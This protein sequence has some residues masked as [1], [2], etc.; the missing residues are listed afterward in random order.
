MTSIFPFT[1]L[2]AIGARHTAPRLWPA[3]VG[4][5]LVLLTACALAPLHGSAPSQP[6]AEGAVALRGQ[7]TVDAST[8]AASP[9][10]L[11][12]PA[13]SV[14]PTSVAPSPTPLPTATPDPRGTLLERRHLATVQRDQINQTSARLYPSGT[15]LP[16]RYPVDRFHIR[17]LSTDATGAPLEVVAQLFVPRVEAALSAPVFV[18]GAGTTGLGDQCAPSREQPTVRNWGDYL[19]HMQSYATQGY[20]AI[21]PDY[22]GFNDESQLQRYFIADLEG[23]VLLD[24]ARAVY[25]F[26]EDAA[27]PV[28]PERAVFFAGYSQGGHAAFAARDAAPRYAPDVPIAGAIGH[29]ATTDVKALLRDSPY[30]APYVLYAYAD[31]YGTDAVDVSRLLLPRWLPSLAVEM[32]TKCIDAMPGYYGNEPRQLY[33]AGFLNALF[34]DRLGESFPALDEVL[35]RNSTGLVPS[36]VPALLLQGTAD[37]IVPPRTQEAFVAKLCAAGGRVTYLTYPNVHHFQ[38]RQVSFK[39]TLAWM[40]TIRTGGTPRT[41]CTG[42]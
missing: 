30:F 38:T 6:A 14:S 12:R 18:Y 39:D 13:A 37:P 42:S 11:V 23:R 10:P 32:T 4:A 17:F 29:G 7:A 34:S 19:A 5:A 26:F 36:R 25:R 8:A 33:Q 20:V 31:Y 24:A 22:A 9:T 15:S 41:A 40:E 2:A 21:L 28:V 16:A 3:L 35:D 1:R 27:A